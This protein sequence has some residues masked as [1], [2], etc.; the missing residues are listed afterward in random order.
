MKLIE[1]V[2]KQIRENRSRSLAFFISLLLHLTFFLFT[3]WQTPHSIRPQEI[4]EITLQEENS[5]EKLRKTPLKKEMQVV[6]QDKNRVNDEID[7]KARFLGRHNQRVAKQTKATAHG[8]WNNQAAGQIQSQL[9]KQKING[10]SKSPAKNLARE[11]GTLPT[12]AELKPTFDWEP[13]TTHGNSPDEKQVS[14]Q[15]DYL[16]DVD[17]G[18]QTLLNTREFVYYSYYSR[19]KNQLQQ[20]WGLKIKEKMRKLFQSGR[21]IASKDRITQIVI[22]LNRQGVLQKVTIIGE[23]GVRDL[24]E[25]AVEAFKAAAPFPNPPRGI[26]ERDGTVKIHWDFVLEA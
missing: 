12:L 22:T 16:Q 20:H 2:K 3:L 11:N 24:D 23:S 6:E 21:Q 9:K 25:A 17:D 26:I 19:I 7:E 13:V 5:G 4:I 10:H 18:I 1:K 8:K 14:Q 15:D